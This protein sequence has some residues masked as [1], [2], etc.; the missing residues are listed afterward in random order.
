MDG[1]PLRLSDTLRRLLTVFLNHPNEVLTWHQLHEL[2]WRS[3][4][5]NT[6]RN[7]V[8]RTV[9]QL[10]KAL[11]AQAGKSQK[12]LNS[13][14]L[15]TV[16]GSGF[17]FAAN[18]R[19]IEPENSGSEG[20]P[21]SSPSGDAEKF[22][23]ALTVFVTLQNKLE[24]RVKK[25]LQQAVSSTNED[26]KPESYPVNDRY[27]LVPIPLPPF[28]P[29]PDTPHGQ[30]RPKGSRVFANGWYVDYDAKGE[31]EGAGVFRMDLPHYRPRT[32]PIE[33]LFA[34]LV[35]KEP[36]SKREDCLIQVPSFVELEFF[37]NGR[38][39]AEGPSLVLK[40]DPP[41]KKE[42][43]LAVQ[44]CPVTITDSPTALAVAGAHRAQG[45]LA[46]GRSV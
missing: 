32:G 20:P 18:I 9:G 44:R 33:Y 12:E 42:G 29:P 3:V 21:E 46:R 10:R 27:E 35:D 22:V 7:N 15:E 4:G 16:Y 26:D 39:E 2:V 23:K 6:T 45:R 19:L 41:S 38:P 28:I 14:F 37:L 30:Q 8:E 11:M 17:K 31:P 1:N 24:P 5:K 25:L 13:P 43:A 36:S 40:A 34:W